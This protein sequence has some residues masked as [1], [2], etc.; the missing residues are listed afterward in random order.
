MVQVVLNAQ[1]RG[2]PS[3]LE[4][5]QGQI[6]GFFSQLLQGGGV[7]AFVSVVHQPVVRERIPDPSCPT[8]P[9]GGPSFVVMLVW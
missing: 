2:C 1:E 7:R 3:T 8:P 5:T 9:A 4:A 6:D